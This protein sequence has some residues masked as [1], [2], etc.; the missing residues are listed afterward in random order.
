MMAT[1]RNFI[2]FSL[3]KN[4]RLRLLFRKLLLDSTAKIDR[5]QARQGGYLVL[6][7]NIFRITSYSRLIKGEIEKG[8]VLEID[9]KKDTVVFQTVHE[10]EPA[11][12]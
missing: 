11:K 2:I 10:S 7:S 12:K 9:A 3:I 5:R 1:L 8:A 4:P 6:E